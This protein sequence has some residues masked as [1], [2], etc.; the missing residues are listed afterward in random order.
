MITSPTI[1]IAIMAAMPMPNM[2]MSVIGVDTC[3]C[4]VDVGA[5]AG[6]AVRNMAVSACEP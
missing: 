5:P 1:T 4:S 3:G 6:A 2:Y